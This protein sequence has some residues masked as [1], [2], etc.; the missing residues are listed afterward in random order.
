MIVA[1]DR[2]YSN[3]Q[4]IVSLHLPLRT[5][6]AL[7]V[8]SALVVHQ[9]FKRY[10]TYSILAHVLLLL[11]PPRILAIY[12]EDH[13]THFLCILVSYTLYL[14]TLI[15][16]IS[17]YR[18]SPFHPIAHY[19]GPLLNKLSKLW[20]V[21]VVSRGKLH[22]YLKGL[23]EQYGDIVRIGPN[24]VS[25]R[26]P[27]AIVPLMGPD[28]LPKGPFV[29]ALAN[30]K[31]EIDLGKWLGFFT[32]D[33]LSDLAYG[34]GSEMLRLVASHIFGQAPWMGIYAN[35]IPQV[36]ST[37]RRL[38]ESE[39]ARTMERVKNGSIKRDLFYYFN[40]EDCQG[41]ESTPPPIK[42]A[43]SDGSLS[44]IAGTDTAS[45][46]LNNLFYCLLTH[47][48]ACNRLR[49]EVD[50]YYP[51]GENALDTKHHADMPFLNAVI[52]ETLR[53]YPAVPSGSQRVVIKGTCGRAIGPYYLPEWTSAA[54]HFYSVHRDPRNFYPS[55]DAFWPDRWL[56]AAGQK[57]QQ[58]PENFVHNAAA[59]IP[60]SYGPENCVGKALALQEMRMTY[61]RGGTGRFLRINKITSA[62]VDFTS[63]YYDNSVMLIVLCQDNISG[64]KAQRDGFLM[65]MAEIL[66]EAGVAAF[67]CNIDQ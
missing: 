31:S 22:L 15:L 63:L 26:D 61:F 6:L 58:F 39:K 3:F 13:F 54:V 17:L 47:P 10:E 59:F 21:W 57:G 36:S 9:I 53:L 56:I 23:H 45:S 25:I 62:S 4:T 43:I 55:T 65:W 46:T 60:F 18:V 64:V 7:V 35:Y 12:L 8:S 20:M 19:P 5:A 41:A 28:G 67:G 30:Q 48:K 29:E 11:V 42:V 2:M 14:F 40:N 37:I 50:S 32:Y 27:S 34:G 33:L 44:V 66:Y 49:E 52:N 51:A 1:F 24:E 16:S 38:N